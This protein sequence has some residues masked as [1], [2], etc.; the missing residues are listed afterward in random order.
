MKRAVAFFPKE[1]CEA[2]GAG[3]WCPR[4]GGG[5]VMWEGRICLL[6]R[7]QEFGLAWVQTGCRFPGM[8]PRWGCS[9]PA[10]EGELF[11]HADTLH[12]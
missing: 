4:D 9:D 6:S 2:V 8:C 11:H 5:E 7:R 12:H 10:L 3:P 1:S